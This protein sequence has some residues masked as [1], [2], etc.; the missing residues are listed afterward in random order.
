MSCFFRGGN[1]LVGQKIRNT[2]D[3]REQF[4]PV[5]KSFEKQKTWKTT[6]KI[7]RKLENQKNHQKT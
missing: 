1:S 6:P 7:W 5:K 3:T 2:Q 4:K